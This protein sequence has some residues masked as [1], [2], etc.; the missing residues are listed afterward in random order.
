MSLQS[1][2]TIKF[3]DITDEFG[4][5][6]NKNLGAFR[7]NQTIGELQFPLD[8]GIPTSGEIKFSD[9]YSKKLNCVIDFHSGD[10]EDGVE[11]IDKWNDGAV[12]VVGGH[13]SKPSAIDASEWQGGKKIIIHVNKNIGGQNASDTNSSEAE[14]CALR[15]G[16]WRAD[17]ELV[18]DVGGEGMIYGAGGR[19]GN[20]GN[21]GSGGYAGRYGTSAVGVE[22]GGGLTVNIGAGAT[23]HAGY[24]G[25]GGGNG[26]HQ[27]DKGSRRYATGGGGGGGQGYPGGEGG[28]QGSGGSSGGPGSDG[29]PTSAGDGGYGGNNAGEAVAGGG[30]E[31][32]SP[33]EAADGAGGGAGGDGAAFRRAS[34][35]TTASITINNS[36]TLEP[37]I[38]NHAGGGF[39]GG[40]S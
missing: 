23:I 40:V 31:G 35:I 19:G 34:G 2:G 17:T 21:G 30:G 8:S 15:T 9:F 24:G 32:G 1:S 28:T 14:K 22:Y 5:P 11:A 39:P 7:V 36:G 20:G 37:N 33:G 10:P 25:G 3:S 38:I 6:T 29:T 27:Y 12:T 26:A 4:T 13:R 16:P 18:I